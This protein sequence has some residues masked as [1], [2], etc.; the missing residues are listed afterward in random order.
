M[1]TPI[2]HYQFQNILRRVAKFFRNRSRDVEKS[3]EGKANNMS[4]IRYS[5]KATFGL[6]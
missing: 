1:I 5:Y 2:G 3:V 4:K 6:L